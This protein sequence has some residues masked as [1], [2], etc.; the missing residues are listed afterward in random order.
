MFT[1]L[2][3]VHMNFTTGNRMYDCIYR[4]G[5]YRQTAEI[6]GISIAYRSATQKRTI[7]YLFPTDDGVEVVE[8]IAVCC[9]GGFKVK[10]NDIANIVSREMG[11]WK[12]QKTFGS[13]RFVCI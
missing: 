3:N 5:K 13:V 9:S 8:H 2:H 7:P 4:H 6:H 10:P 12:C 1:S 11:E